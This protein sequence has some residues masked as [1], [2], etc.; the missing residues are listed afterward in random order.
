M[1][2]I[3]SLLTIFSLENGFL[4]NLMELFL[5]HADTPTNPTLAKNDRSC[6]Y[7]LL[8]RTDRAAGLSILA[9]QACR[10]DQWEVR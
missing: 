8:F 6:G 3:F 7:E 9:Q 10:R 1:F 2:S 5:I 4:V